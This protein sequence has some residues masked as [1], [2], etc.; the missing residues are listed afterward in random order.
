MFEQLI[1]EAES[2]LNLSAAS[3]TALVRGLLSL[4]LSERGGADGFIDLFRRA[5]L[6]D[7]ITSW[8]GGEEGR[9]LTAAH[10]ESALGP[11]ALDRLAASSGLTRVV[12]APAAA[13]LLPRM[14]G[15][16]TPN[17]VLPSNSEILSQVSSYIDEPV[18]SPVARRPLESRIVNRPHRAGWP[19][20]LPLALAAAALIA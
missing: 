12:V 1:A 5:G 9:T 19:S 20:W 2:R 14:I 8:F 15:R 13:F 6:G 16:L 11:T 3:V 10:V 7:V 17:G 4:M 18:V